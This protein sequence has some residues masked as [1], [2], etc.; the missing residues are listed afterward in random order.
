MHM[1]FSFPWDSILRWSVFLNYWLIV[2]VQDENKTI[3][4]PT[5]RGIWRTATEE[6][7]LSRLFVVSISLPQGQDLTTLNCFILIAG[8]KCQR[9]THILFCL[10]RNDCIEPPCA[11]SCNVYLSGGWY[12]PKN[13]KEKKMLQILMISTI[14]CYRSCVIHTNTWLDGNRLVVSQQWHLE[15]WYNVAYLIISMQPMPCTIWMKAFYNYDTIWY[16]IQ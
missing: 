9:S 3:C 2:L 13:N 4:A 12:F 16:C 8:S 5:W 7:G 11:I 14:C 1:I 10:I 6:N 15:V